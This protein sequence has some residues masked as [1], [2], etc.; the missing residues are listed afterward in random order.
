ME[1]AFV[2]RLQYPFF[3]VSLHREGVILTKRIFFLDNLKAFIVGI[4]VLFHAAMCYMAY[5]PEWWYV[6][7]TQHTV[8]ATLF[9]IWADVFIMPVMFFVSGYFGILSLSRRSQK[10]FWRSKWIRIGFPWIFGAMLIA[11]CI[12][13]LMIAS[14]DIPMSF[15]EF[16]SRMFWGVAYEQ[17]HYWY[18]GALMALYGLLALA[19][20]L[21]P[22]WKMQLPASGPSGLFF[23]GVLL[24]G[25]VGSGVVNWFVPDG[26]WIHPL[27]ILVLQPTRVP[28]YLLYFFLGVYAWRRQWFLPDAYQPE[29]GVWLPVFILLSAAYVL[30]RMLPMEPQTVSLESAAIRAV[31]HSLCCMTAVWALLAF[32]ARYLAFTTKRLGVLAAVSYPVYYLHQFFV[33]EAAW[34]FRPLQLPVGIKYLLTC[35]LALVVCFL[36]SRYLLLRLPCF[37]ESRQAMVSVSDRKGPQEKQ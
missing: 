33:Q 17:A 21:R 15:G 1:L 26:T 12:A 3:I 28:L 31:F 4:M 13:Y 29:A 19:V 16:Y 34:L 2:R 6:L 24:A 9:V 5:A 7:D 8:Y 27:Y 37:K 10:S 11:P 23:I 35:A 20:K 32:F 22:A 25:A 14:R 36:L 18:L 30:F